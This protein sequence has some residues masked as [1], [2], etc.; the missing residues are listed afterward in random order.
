[1]GH[2]QDRWFSTRVDPATGKTVRTK[3]DRHGTGMRYRVRYLDPEGTERNKGFPDRAKRQAELFLAEV[4]SAKQQGT[5]LDPTAG[6]V[7]FETYAEQWLAGQTFKATTRTNVPSRLRS[8][9][10]PYLGRYELRAITPTVIRGWLRWMQER[11]VAASYR[12][13]CF[14]HVSAILTAAVDDRRIGA[15]PCTARSVTKPQ[16][17]KRKVIPW[18]DVRVKA[19]RLALP[20]RVQVVVDLGAGC[21]LRQGEIFGLSPADLDL[22]QNV[23]HVVRQIQQVDSTLVFCKPKREKE[24][25]VP[26]PAN[27]LRAITEHLTIFPA[28]R[29]TLP[30]EEPDGETHTL[31]L[32]LTD[33]RELPW[34]RQTFNSVMWQ[35]SLRRAG[36]P[37]GNREDGTHALRHYYAS[38]LLDGGESI[39]AVSEYLGHSDPGFTLRTYTH[40]MPSSHERTRRVVDERLYPPDGPHTAQDADPEHNSSSEDMTVKT[41]SKETG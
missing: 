6:R 26:L 21:G 20:P 14:V 9:A 31:Y 39:K 7:T 41:G 24:R 38:V 35:P 3:T 4:E 16:L 13:V 10:Y 23:V 40:L 22:E 19:V 34:W 32:V 11:K 28:A 33:D 30:W 8:Q 12:V 15:N 2:I 18:T 29:V 17:D 5:Y 37:G 36:V 27:V 1:M 25:D